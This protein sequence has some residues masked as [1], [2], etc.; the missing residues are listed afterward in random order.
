ML[1]HCVQ[2]VCLTEARAAIQ[3]E[4]VVGLTRLLSHGHRRSVRKAI[5]VAH[6]EGVER[7]ARVKHQIAV[8]NFL[9]GG[10]LAAGRL[11]RS[12]CRAVALGDFEFNVQL[13]AAGG[14]QSLLQQFQVIVLQPDFRK[15]IRHLKG[16]GRLVQ[17][18]RLHR[19]EPQVVGLGV[20][21]GPDLIRGLCPNFINGWVH[22]FGSKHQSSKCTFQ[23]SA[24]LIPAR[25]KGI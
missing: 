18:H 12:G 21:E 23:Y 19:G 3:E 24:G 25:P 16:D 10:F 9:N 7:I 22:R 1:T 20:E 17:G 2:Q 14:G 5:V 13:A 4:R 6:H 15:F 8:I 11:G